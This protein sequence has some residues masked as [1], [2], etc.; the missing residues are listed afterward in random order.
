MKRGSS[1]QFE[2]LQQTPLASRIRSFYTNRKL[3]LFEVTGLLARA[4]V[5]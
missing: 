1:E 4:R 2:N 3:G 5:E